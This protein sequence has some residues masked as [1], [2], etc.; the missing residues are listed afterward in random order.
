VPGGVSVA[1]PP[2]GKA[3][4]GAGGL[5]GVITKALA[6]GTGAAGGFLVDPQVAAAITT[7]MRARSAIMRLGP[8]TV[9]VEKELAITS[10]ASGATA[11]WVLENA[12]IPVS[13][14]TFAQS[15]L[16]RPKELAA[17]VPIS[18]R[19][20]RDAS[21]SPDIEQVL[22]EDLAEIMSLRLDLSCIQGA[23]GV[24]PLGIRNTT[25]LTSAPDL[26]PN[27][28][29]PTFD[30]LKNMVARLRAVNA[31]FS[32]PGWLFHPRLLNTLE[33][34]KDSTGR[35]LAESELL[36]FDATGGGGTLLGYH[37]ETSSQVPVNVA[38][39][40][41]PDTTYVIFG[42]D[43]GTEAWIGQ[44]QELTIEASGEATYTTD[45][46]TTW[47]SAFQNRQQVF[48][49]VLTA[50]FGLRRPQLFTSMAGVRPL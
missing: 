49:S 28:A 48:R 2:S 30:D 20:L 38:A 8:R 26:G 35:Y 12:A 5:T 9:P 43:W 17:L 36:T 25:G 42:S 50:D 3:L 44:N 39:G 37:F 21:G 6:E 23:G 34:L 15:V 7:L 31:P 22:R 19:L 10:I 24:E 45:G 47:T 27:G 14:E 1:E 11:S 16:L 41:S 4:G 32:S 13:E 29:V 40:T 33:R 18:N 46:G